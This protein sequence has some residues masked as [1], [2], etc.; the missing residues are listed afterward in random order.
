MG[1]NFLSADS[2]NRQDEY[3]G[4]LQGRTKFLID[5]VKVVRNEVRSDY[6]ISVRIDGSDFKKEGFTIEESKKIAHMLEISGANILSVSGS[7]YG[8]YPMT[9]PPLY[10][11]KASF[12]ERV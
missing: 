5:I 6:P 1:S 11:E 4:D 7:I 3:R 8:W 10:T 12:M 9:I 2:N